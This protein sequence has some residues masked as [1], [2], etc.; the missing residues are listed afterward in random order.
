[1]S[2]MEAEGSARI[3]KFLFGFAPNPALQIVGEMTLNR[4]TGSGSDLAGSLHSTSRCSMALSIP[5]VY[6]P[7]WRFAA[8]SSVSARSLPLPVLRLSVITSMIQTWQIRALPLFSDRI[9]KREETHER[10]REICNG[11]KQVRQLA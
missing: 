2:A 10:S 8:E 1:M 7:V 6:L 4:R 3:W 11:A 5:A 9:Q